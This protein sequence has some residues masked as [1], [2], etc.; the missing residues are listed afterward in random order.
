MPTFWKEATPS[1]KVRRALKTQARKANLT[2]SKDEVRF[3]DRG[4]RVPMCGCRR[5]RLR[6]EVSHNPKAHQG[7]GG[8]PAED[9]N[10]ARNLMLVCAERHKDNPISLDRGALKWEPIYPERG[11]N[12]PVRWY[13]D[14]ALFVYLTEQATERPSSPVWFELAYE[15]ALGQLGPMSPQQVTVARAL[16]RMEL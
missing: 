13:V 11:A 10:D 1:G 15:A 7:M 16:A 3:R 14:A 6:L 9:R 12:G 4:C 2:E 8:N 5:F